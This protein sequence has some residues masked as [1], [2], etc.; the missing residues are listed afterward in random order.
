MFRNAF[1]KHSFSS[2]NSES[3]EDNS[4]LCD[5]CKLLGYCKGYRLDNFKLPNKFITKVRKN[6]FD[7]NYYTAKIPFRVS[8][9]EGYSHYAKEYLQKAYDAF[10]TDDFETALLHF[11]TVEPGGANYSNSNYFLALTYFMMG[12][13]EMSHLHMQICMDNTYYTRE[14][15]TSFLDECSNLSGSALFNELQSGDKLII[16]SINKKI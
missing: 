11:K 15:F 6:S 8:T 2:E 9:N 5:E 16:S 1:S 13:Y 12:D 4:G 10:H 3:S 14:D 7:L